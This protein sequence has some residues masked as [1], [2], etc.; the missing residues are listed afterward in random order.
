[1]PT[2]GNTKYKLLV[3]AACC[4]LSLVFAA[5]GFGAAVFGAEDDPVR[6]RESVAIDTDLTAQRQLELA[7]IHLAQKRWTE[8]IDLI[9]QAAAGIPGSL[10]NAAAG[11]YLNVD[12]YAQLLL[13]SLPPEGLAA[14]RKNVDETARQAFEDAVRN[15]DVAALRNL[16]R[17]SFVS[18]AAEDALMTL[19]QW[20]WE[21]GNL[22]AARANWEWLVPLR[23]RPALGTLPPVLRYPD[24]RADR[25]E[26]LARLVMCSIVEG[27]EDRSATERHAFRR[28]CPQA[29]GQLAG[30]TGILADL[31]DQVAM[32]ARNWKFP[33]RRGGDDVRGQRGPQR[34]AAGG[35]RRRGPASG[36][37]ICRPIPTRRPPRCRPL[38]AAKF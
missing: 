27:D 14:A 34:R 20:S 37:S 9:H 38:E 33:P 4:G 11:R 26:L 7:R 2:R 22:T 28:M 35:N 24:P 3:R 21:E 16:V 32:T 36:R 13:S 25:A 18:R 6:F 29:Q 23:N 5:A 1:M 31:L 19:G 30:R 10:V 15:R 12:L 8:A 17:D